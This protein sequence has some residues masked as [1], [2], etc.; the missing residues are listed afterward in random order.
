[1]FALEQLSRN[2]EGMT[3]RAWL[4]IGGLSLFCMTLPRLLNAEAAQAPAARKNTN[5][6]LLW[7]NGGLANIDTLDRL[8]LRAWEGPHDRQLAEARGAD[9]HVR[10]GD[11]NVDG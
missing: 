10:L 8:A 4:Q 3:R 1:M 6:I 11:T 7:T 5:F 9:R 2:C